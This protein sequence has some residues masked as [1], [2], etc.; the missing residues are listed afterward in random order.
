[1]QGAS[2]TIARAGDAPRAVARRTPGAP[3]HRPR[4]A[5]P[6]PPTSPCARS[7]GPTA[8]RRLRF[9]SPS[10]GRPPARRARP[11][12]TRYACAA[13]SDAADPA[14]NRALPRLDTPRRLLPQPPETR[15]RPAH[16]RSSPARTR[17]SSSGTLV[18]R[19]DVQEILR[20]PFARRAWEDAPG[21]GLLVAGLVQH[22]HRLLQTSWSAAPSCTA[23]ESNLTARVT[24]SKA[25]SQPCRPRRRRRAAPLATRGAVSDLAVAVG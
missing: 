21:P 15:R 19:R 13:T 9:R 24:Q 17:A 12:S 4:A 22:N 11:R 1:M 10:T 7:C 18:Q 6:P 8:A 16:R 5:A 2:A 3:A 23:S 25:C 14:E 20:R